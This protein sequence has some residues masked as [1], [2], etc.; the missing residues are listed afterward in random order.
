MVRLVE[1]RADEVVHGGIHHDELL[2]R[3]ALAVEDPR[4]QHARLA[5]DGAAG[6]E[7]QEQVPALHLG[8]NRRHER[9]DLRGK[10]SGQ[11]GHAQAT[12]QIE[13]AD[14]DAA[15]AQPLDQRHHLV[16]GFEDGARI[17]D[18]RADV[19]AHAVHDQARQA[20]GTLID[21]LHL[22]DADPELVLAQ[23]GDDVGMGLRTD[24]RIH[25][26]GDAR[27]NAAP[28]RQRVEERQLGLGLAIEAVYA[29]SQR[30]LHLARGLAHA[31]KDHPGGLSA[32]LQHAKKLA[33]RNDVE[34]SP[35]PGQQGRHAQAGVGLHGIADAV[36]EAGQRFVISAVVLENGAAR[37]DVAGR[38]GL[39]RDVGQ[40]D[41][42][43]VEVVGVVVA[44]MGHG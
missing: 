7:R 2:R 20:A 14:R 6:L 44:G 9:S 11:V 38:P 19:A 15:L 12:A 23:A 13:R 33:A 10:L 30:V 29:R 3:A 37:V 36:R 42:L 31:R 16:Y 18:L 5:H 8:P 21:G 35:C 25:A 39:G 28:R 22:R 4:E 40:G 27:P 41:S 24:V 17:Q 1:R 26:H 43:G 34:A 32:G